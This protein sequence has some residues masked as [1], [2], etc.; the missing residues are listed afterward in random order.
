MPPSAPKAVR[1]AVRR[2]DREAL[3]LDPRDQRA[4]ERQIALRRFDGVQRAIEPAPPD[5]LED[6]DAARPG[7]NPDQPDPFTTRRLQPEQP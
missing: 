7:E 1:N 6:R 4:D 5:R 2:G 3:G